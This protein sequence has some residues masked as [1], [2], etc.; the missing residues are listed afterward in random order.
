MKKPSFVIK[1]NFEGLFFTKQNAVLGTFEEVPKGSDFTVRIYE[2]K[3]TEPEF[4]DEYKPDDYANRDSI[5]LRGADNITVYPNA[6]SPF[7]NENTFS[8]SQVVLI[9]PKIIKTWNHNGKTYGKLSSD[10][11]GQTSVN[12]NDDVKNKDKTEAKS[13]TEDENNVQN[14]DGSNS[15]EGDGLLRKS[16]DDNWNRENGKHAN[17]GC[18]SGLQGLLPRFDGCFSS[19]IN[20]LKWLLLLAL[21]FWLIRSC[22][23]T[24]FSKFNFCD[25][26]QKLEEESQILKKELDEK[27]KIYKEELKKSLQLFSNIYFY[28]DT[29]EIRNVSEANVQQL[30][31]FLKKHKSA[32]VRLEGHSNQVSK[33]NIS[34]KRAEA[35]RKRL[36][37]A[38]INE[39]RIQ[40]IGNENKKLLQDSSKLFLENNNKKYN[41]N[42][43]VEVIL[44]D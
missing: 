33:K 28:G 15:N 10:F 3:L 30:I 34:L 12:V 19:L 4:F 35:V 18:L 7:D 16:E 43:R 9:N 8:F 41:L 13:G 32:N 23:D 20:L 5:I 1:G 14:G 17:K 36:T 27:K 24:N 6:Q 29:D 44:I 2:G 40:V 11:I 38:K 37:E 26:L 39:S 42:M 22:K 25:D 31:E 21:L